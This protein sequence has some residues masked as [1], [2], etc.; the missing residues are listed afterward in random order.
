MIITTGWSC[1]LFLLGPANFDLPR[2]SN[3]SMAAHTIK[4][5]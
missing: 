1:D 2:A 5:V 3:L 4:S